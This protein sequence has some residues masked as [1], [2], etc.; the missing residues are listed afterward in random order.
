MCCLLDSEF[1]RQMVNVSRI[2]I[3]SA[4]V[5]G[6]YFGDGEH[7]HSKSH[8]PAYTGMASTMA[9]IKHTGFD[10]FT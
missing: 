9:L 10:N 5:N 2:Y 1:S 7:L 4:G 8:I 3:M 6:M